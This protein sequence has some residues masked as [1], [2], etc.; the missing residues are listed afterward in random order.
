ML[1]Q[2]RNCTA[3]ALLQCLFAALQVTFICT[4]NRGSDIPPPLLDRLEVVQLAGYTQDEKV[5]AMCH[6]C[7]DAVSCLHAADPIGLFM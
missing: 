3:Y 2:R 4:A 7:R 1:Q 6:V 5:S